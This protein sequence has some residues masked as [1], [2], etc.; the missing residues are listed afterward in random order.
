MK[1]HE[2]ETVELSQDYTIFEAVLSDMPEA[3]QDKAKEIDG[4]EYDAQGFGA[5]VGYDIAK[6][7]F[8]F[9]TDEDTVTGNGNIFYVDDEGDRH[10]FRVEIGDELTKQI[11]DACNR[12]NG[13]IETPEGYT[14]QK[15]VQFD[16]DFGLV[17]AKK[18]HQTFP[19]SSWMFKETEE[20]RR[21]YIW[22]RY[23]ADEK[24]A[25]KAFANAIAVHTEHER[26]F[27]FRQ[28][29]PTTWKSGKKP[30]IKAKLAA[31]PVVGDKPAVKTKDR[32][33]R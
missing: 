25:E 6:N 21:D 3:V 7:N 31:K 18:D 9:F 10:W 24:T 5:C 32:E 20:G 4:Q 22:S 14:I 15:T 33:A 26:T 2:I 27:Y 30:S 1:F 23:Y 12:I 8:F 29:K 28:V 16:R 17:L 11:F 19:F 13:C